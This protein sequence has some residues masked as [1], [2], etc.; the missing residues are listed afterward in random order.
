MRQFV[1][2]PN[3]PYRAKEPVHF[4]HTA[5]INIV[6]VKI[7]CVCQ[8]KLPHAVGIELLSYSMQRSQSN[9]VSWNVRARGGNILFPTIT[10][11][12]W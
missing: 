12:N 6:N 3:H 10:H 7:V 8:S 9:S 5:G 2:V 11:H 4:I 1:K